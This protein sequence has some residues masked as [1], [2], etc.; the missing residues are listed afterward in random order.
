MSLSEAFSYSS[1]SRNH[2]LATRIRRIT[3]QGSVLAAIIVASAAGYEW[4][5]SLA[6]FVSTDD[7]YVGGDVTVI[8]PKVAGF[9]ANVAVT[10]N[11]TVHAGDVLVRLDDRDFRAALQKAEATVASKQ[12]AIANL[13]SQRSLQ[14][15]VIAVAESEISFA[16]AEIVRAQK[17]Q[18]RAQ[19]LSAI[20]GIA[21]QNVEQ[22]QAV[23]K[24]AVA[25]GDKARASLTATERQLGVLA[26]EKQQ[27]QADLAQAKS[28]R[29]IARLNLGY[30]ELRAPVDGVVGNRTARDG[31]FA[32]IGAELVSL[33]PS[34]GLWVDANFKEDQLSR[35]HPGETVSIRAD[36][37]AGE[38]FHGHVASIA[39]ATGATFSILPAEN[40]TGNFTKIVQRVPVRI[41]LDGNASQ[42]GRLRPGLSTAVTV[43]ARTGG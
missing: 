34:R 7:A 18:S 14:E 19:Q 37:L 4:W 31:A 12:A 43:D 15:A 32:A 16:E 29:D 5:Q 3:M 41:V 11:Q 42:L 28:D 30:T 2:Q 36:T 26:T 33:V 20:G 35:I 17:E 23:Y 27:A 25:S 40:A 22:S 13:D 8:A 21:L 1:T 24:Q 38:V 9:I 10:D 39:P 6:D